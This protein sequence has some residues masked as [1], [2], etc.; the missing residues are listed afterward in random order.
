M[1]VGETTMV[2]MNLPGEGTACQK[3]SGGEET[4]YQIFLKNGAGGGDENSRPFVDQETHLLSGLC[5]EWSYEICSRGL[6]GPVD[7]LLPPPWL[8]SE[9]YCGMINL[10][11]EDAAELVVL[12][13]L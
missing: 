7:G 3:A 10:Y 5:W 6:M 11:D 4:G 2:G 8:C 12:G 1:A 13:K 9:S